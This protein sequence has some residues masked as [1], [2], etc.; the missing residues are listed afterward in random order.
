MVTQQSPNETSPNQPHARHRDPLSWFPTAIVVSCVGFAIVIF[1]ALNQAF[2]WNIPG[3]SFFTPIGL[4]LSVTCAIPF[5]FEKDIA[6]TARILFIVFIVPF[7]IF[8]AFL[9]IDAPNSNNKEQFKGL[10]L[11][12]FIQAL[13]YIADYCVIRSSIKRNVTID[14]HS[15]ILY[16]VLVC[17]AV[18]VMNFPGNF[19]LA[20]FIGSSF[21]GFMTFTQL[22]DLWSVLVKVL[23][24]PEPEHTPQQTNA[25][26]SVKQ[27]EA[28]NE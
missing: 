11:F 21:L 18:M 17:L 20:S 15:M 1:Y 22:K 7:V 5:L 24:A 28:G 3:D 9:F 2:S 12:C 13:I 10:G 27:E 16:P 23:T 6:Q 14:I 4:V 8:G 19:G 25:D 26:S